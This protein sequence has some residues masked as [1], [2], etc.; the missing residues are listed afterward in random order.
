MK[1]FRKDKEAKTIVVGAG[2]AGLTIAYRLQQKG[3]DVEVY[4]ARSRVGGRVHSIWQENAEGGFSLG[5]LGAQNIT[6]G[7]EATHMFA[8]IKEFGLEIE[9]YSLEFSRI[10]YDGHK[11][12]DVHNLLREQN[13][14]S[15]ELK[16]KLKQL[17][18]SS[19]SMKEVIDKLFPQNSILKR[20]LN[21]QI[22]AFEGSRPELLSTSYIKT[23]EYGLLGGIAPALQVQGY[24]PVLELASLKQGNAVLPI[25]ISQLLHNPVHFNKVLE[26][27]GMTHGQKIEL[28]FK[29]GAK[30]ICDKLIL[31]IP[32]SVY[33]DIDF[34][35]MVISVDKLQTIQN[36]QFGTNA[37]IMIPFIDK[38]KEYNA[39]FT[40]HMAA[41]LNMDRKLLN[42]YFAGS[43]GE[44]LLQ[45]YKKHY[46]DALTAI[47]TN[48]TLEKITDKTPEIARDENFYHYH[49][50]VV[51]SWVDD[52]FAKGSYSCL[53]LN[54]NKMMSKKNK[55]HNI[56]VK[57]IFEPLNEQVFFVGEHTTIIEEIGTM[58]AA[59]ESGERISKL[60]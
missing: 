60:F 15:K 33:K 29:D 6:D 14:N 32:S 8:L 37:K 16:A 19:K 31:A 28:C 54:I 56:N 1:L 20:V 40:D 12:Y 55:Y 52:P 24:K 23:L 36:I 2:L 47:K 30:K 18:Q 43:V 9:S 21:F 53:G 34:D 35:P 45:N 42:L 7:G 13:F 44:N 51:K 26:K 39:V 10:F 22:T 57:S 3:Y 5:E 50:P 46:N 25:K 49:C 11:A 4:E 58:E 27:V 41:F 38:K 48:F 17:A 59:I